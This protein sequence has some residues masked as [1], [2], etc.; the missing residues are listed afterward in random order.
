MYLTTLTICADRRQLKKE[1]EKEKKKD[2]LMS[3]VIYICWF[4]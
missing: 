3:V 2:E 1:K 4:V